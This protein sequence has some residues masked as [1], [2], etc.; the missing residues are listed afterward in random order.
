MIRKKL[1]FLML[2]IALLSGLATASPAGLSEQEKALVKKVDKQL[3]C[4][5]GCSLTV[6]DCRVAMTC[7]ESEKLEKEVIEYVKAGLG[8]DQ[9]LRAMR[10]KYGESILAAPTK[11]GFNITAWTLPFIALLVGGWVATRYIKKWKGNSQASPK[12]TDSVAPTAEAAD[13]YE[14]RV[15]EELKRFD[16]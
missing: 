1:Q 8:V 11:E 5:C 6:A 4:F 3:A 15:E 13:Q 10:E 2:Y 16:A 14:Q 9:I 12:P 7:G